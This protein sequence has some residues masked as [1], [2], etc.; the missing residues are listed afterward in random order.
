L[1]NSDRSQL[2]HALEEDWWLL[3][4]DDDFLAPVE[5]EQLSHAGILSVDQT[6]K[7]IGEV[8]KAV[9]A[10]LDESHDSERTIHYL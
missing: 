7:R 9:D 5:R 6:G 8:V 2:A 1:G 3:T 10:F 4:F